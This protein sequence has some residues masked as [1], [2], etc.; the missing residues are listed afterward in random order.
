MAAPFHR[1]D[2][3]F[4]A[5][6][7]YAEFPEARGRES[8]LGRVLAAEAA[9]RRRDFTRWQWMYANALGSNHPWALEAVK[10]DEQRAAESAGRFLVSGARVRRV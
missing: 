8:S 5:E 7:Y 1:P 2:G 6:A 10:S 3:E 4:D 9:Q